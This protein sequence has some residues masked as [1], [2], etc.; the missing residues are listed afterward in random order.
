[1]TD[2][3][4]DAARMMK[5]MIM[6]ETK[7]PQDVT[8]RLEAG[9]R[10]IAE[11]A[12]Q[13]NECIEFWRGNQYI[14][15]NSGGYISRQG[16]L[17][18]ELG[19]PRHRIRQTRNII[20]D[21]VRH[22]VSAA[23]QRVP[24]YQIL[25]STSDQEDV[26]AA[27]IAS[28]VARFGYDKWKV[29]EVTE[30]VVTYSLITK[31]GEGFAWPYWDTSSGPIIDPEEHIGIGEVKI[32]VYGPN[33]V[34]WEPGVRFEDARWY[35]VRQAKSQSAVESIQGFLGFKVKPDATADPEASQKGGTDRSADNKLVMVTEY[36]ER[37]CQKYPQGRRLVIVNDKLAVEPMDYPNQDASG[38]VVDEPPFE[39][40]AYILDPESDRDMGLVGHLLDAQRT[41]NDCNNK[42]LEWKNL[43]LNPQLIAPL[44]A[45]SKRQRITD[46]PG[47]VFTYNPVNGMKPEW[48]Q[49]PPIPQELQQIKMD[50]LEDVKRIAAQNAYPQDASGKALQ[51]LIERDS[52]ARQAFTARLA[53]F[54]SRLMRRCLVLVARYYTEPR[55]VKV[56]GMFGPDNIADFKGS[57]LNSQVD[58]LVLPESIEPRTRQALEQR[59]MAYAQLG[60]ISGEKAMDAIE[61]GTA[62]D[63]VDSYMLDVSRCHRL[64]RKIMAGPEVFLSEPPVMGQ[65]GLPTASWLPRPQDA[66]P[67]HRTIFSDF[68]K[69]LE[70]EQSEP[71]VQEA[72]NLYL[73]ALDYLEQAKAAQQAMQQTQMAESLGMSNAAK[74]A[75]VAPL[76]SQSADAFRPQNGGM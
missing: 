6:Q 41:Y 24:D 75:S 21:V 52:N 20:M 9:K 13:N 46:E 51:V 19:K 36:L 73:Q 65:D 30:K 57:D 59:V 42:Q 5:A 35:V 28:K 56:N 29:R 70:Y 49:T 10:R 67:V 58:V 8:E 53:E 54:H 66:I 76:P 17:I 33:E 27:R 11:F 63:I 69:T 14:Y 40:L 71:P 74:P 72:V 55:M 48:R 16:T 18:N 61:K 32:G 62:A 12:S 50:A 3:A 1:M 25:P 26:S 7:V 39:K 31:T 47:A 37:P 23:T 68:S 4:A 15:R 22:E 38:Q 44:G 43:A 45:F 60:W 64:L 34:G 2:V